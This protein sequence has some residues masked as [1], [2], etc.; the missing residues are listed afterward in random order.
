MKN[1]KKFKT[2]IF[3]TD[4]NLKASCMKKMLRP[5]LHAKV[6]SANVVVRG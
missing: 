2:R 4:S 6:H 1:L 3:E 5:K